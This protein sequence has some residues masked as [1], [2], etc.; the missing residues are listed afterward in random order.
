MS[1]SLEAGHPM[2]PAGFRKSI[3]FALSRLLGGSLEQMMFQWRRGK[4]PF[5]KPRR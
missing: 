5:V 2:K 1:V 4:P 3:T